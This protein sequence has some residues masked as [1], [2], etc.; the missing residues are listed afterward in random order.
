MVA[1]VT[2]TLA[3]IVG[4]VAWGSWVQATGRVVTH[5]NLT[6]QLARIEARQEVLICLAALPITATAA[7]AE[8]CRAAA[9]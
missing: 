3:V 1:M 8:A 9:E 2:L 6:E 4:V 7:D 5:E